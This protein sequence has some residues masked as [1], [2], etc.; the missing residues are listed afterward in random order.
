MI[1]KFSVHHSS[2]QRRQDELRDSRDRHATPE[3]QSHK[4]PPQQNGRKCLLFT[5]VLLLLIGLGCNVDLT[6]KEEKKDTQEQVAAQNK[7]HY[8]LLATSTAFSALGL[9]QAMILLVAENRRILKTLRFSEAVCCL[10]SVFIDSLVM[11]DNHQAENSNST[12]NN[13]QVST[14]AV[15]CISLGGV[16]SFCGSIITSKKNNDDDGEQTTN[17]MWRRQTKLDQ[18]QH[19]HRGA[20]I[21]TSNSISNSDPLE[22]KL[23]DLDDLARDLAA[24]DEEEGSRR[25]RRRPTMEEQYRPHI[26]GTFV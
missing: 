12:N 25:S 17:T 18:Q 8:N 26:S 5:A 21:A 16:L 1:F 24:R 20:H 9:I 2:W 14:T 23:E 19:Q 22:L 4:K 3:L 11:Y 13:W 7:H 15:V 10:V 6:Q